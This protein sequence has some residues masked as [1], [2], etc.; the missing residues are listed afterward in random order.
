MDLLNRSIFELSSGELQIV[1][2]ARAILQNPKVIVFDEPTSNLD[3]KNQL[4]VLN[5]IVCIGKTAI[6]TLM[7]LGSDKSNGGYVCAGNVF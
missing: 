5:Q 7:S 6:L 3:I 2:I 4:I 1:K